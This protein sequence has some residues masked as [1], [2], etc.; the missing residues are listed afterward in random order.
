[1]R[2]LSFYLNTAH[3]APCSGTI[4]RWRYCYYRPATVV[5]SDRYRVTWAVYRRMGSGDNTHY[6]IVESSVNTVTRGVPG[7]GNFW[8]Q[9]R[10]VL[11]FDIEAGDI[12]GACIFQ[13]SQADKQQMDI[14]GQANGSSLMQMP[15]SRQC[16]YFA[17]PSNIS[18]SQLSTTD[19]RTLHLSATITS[20][21]TRL[22]SY[23][24]NIIMCFLLTF[25]SRA[26]SNH[27]SSSYYNVH[28]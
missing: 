11:R 16:S 8:C 22:I 5:N 10:N 20:M 26:H 7:S 1:M 15:V 6:E 28:N 24:H 12:V 14:V 3:P 2:N 27:L 4:T 9:N 17:M 13:P 19:S 18:S 21:F 25:V 23:I